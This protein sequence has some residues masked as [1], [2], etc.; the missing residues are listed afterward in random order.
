MEV[1]VVLG[2]S[3]DST[4]YSF[5]AIQ[6]LKNFGHRPIPIH[7]KESEILGLSVYKDLKTLLGEGIKVDTVTVYLRPEISQ[8]YESDLIKLVPK[9]VIFNPGAENPELEKKLLQ[10]GIKIEEACTLVLLQTHQ[11]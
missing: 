1:V 10:S 6:M 8:T 3:N 5:K 9:R 2:A 11:F 4:R 7:P